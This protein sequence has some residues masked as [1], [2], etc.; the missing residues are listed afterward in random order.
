[1]TG[2]WGYIGVDEHPSHWQADFIVD[3]VHGL[4]ELLFAG[5]S[6]GANS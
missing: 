3:S 4:D 2:G 1:M 5:E 6:A